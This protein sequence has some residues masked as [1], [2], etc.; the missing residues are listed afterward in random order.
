VTLNQKPVV[1][2]TAGPPD[3]GQS[4]VTASPATIQVGTGTSTITVTVKDAGGNRVSGATVSLD[5][6]GATVTSPGATDNNGVTTGTLSSDVAG[7]KT[8]TATVNGSTQISQTA[9][10]NVT[11][12]PT[13]TVEQTLLTAGNHTTNQK[14]Y[15]TAS[16]SPAPNSLVTVAI[17]GHRSST[18]APIPTV[19]G[20]GMTWTQVATIT[21]DPLSA[22][23][24]TLT[25]YRAMSASPG[26]GPITITFPATVSNAQWIVSQWTGVD[27]SGT[28]GSGAI[29][30]TGTNKADATNGL[31]VTLGAFGHPNNVAYGVFGVNS[32]VAAITPGTGFSEIAEQSS[33]ESPAADLQAEWALD[34][35]TIDATWTNL[36]GGGI[37]LEI[38]AQGAP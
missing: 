20:L 33:I 31:G 23:L 8:V 9:T 7:Q 14:I 12:N 2:V 36:R 32:K 29:G 15:P 34:R 27:Q 30:Q 37:G 5:A 28:N 4:T 6:P 10:V 24:K 3:A 22:P 17:L 38:R 21:Y 35:S 11:D 18:P 25:V 13:G 26:S 1:D 19:S 16:V